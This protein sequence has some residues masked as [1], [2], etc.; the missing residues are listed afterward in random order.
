V[1]TDHNWSDTASEKDGNSA[2]PTPGFLSISH[3][4][5]I[6]GNCKAPG[7]DMPS[8]SHEYHEISDEDVGQSPGFDLGPSLMDEVL[9]ALGGGTGSVAPS[10]YSPH[11]EKD[12]GWKDDSGAS[13]SLP[14]SKRGTLKDTLKKKQATVHV[15]FPSTAQLTI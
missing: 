3:Q 13:N 8:E 9:R 1:K 7:L 6:S 12:Y 4:K 11:L 10:S 14:G 15:S 5:M 2:P